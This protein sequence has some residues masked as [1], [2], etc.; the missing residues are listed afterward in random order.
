MKQP[1]ADRLASL[2][3]EQRALLEFRLQKKAAQSS[4]PSIPIRERRDHLPLSVDQER[5]WFVHQLDPASAAYNIYTAVRFKGKLQLEALTRSLNEIV[6]RHEIMRTCF[7]APDGQPEQLI[8]PSLTAAI[9]LVDLRSIPPEFR[10]REA[11]RLAASNVQRPFDLAHLP[12]F[13]TV[14]LQVQDEEFICPTVFHHIITDWVSFYAFDRELASL[15]GAFREGQPS[16]LEPLSI[17]YADFAAWQRDWLTHKVLDDQVEYWRRRLQ[18]APPL[19]ELPYDRPRP[20]V[21][22]ASGF[23]QPLALSPGDTEFIRE[24]GRRYQLT[25]FI[26]LLALFKILLFRLTRQ[27]HVVVGSPIANRNRPEL[28]K[29]LGFFIN[30]LVFCTETGGDPLFT[31][32]LLRVK[33]T[34]LGAYANQDVPFAK[35]VEEVRPDRDLSRT[36]LTQ[37]VFLFLN[38]EQ[39]GEIRLSGLRILPYMIDSESSKFDMTFS[40]WESESGYSG[41][42]EYN[43][44]LFD[45]TTI[46]RMG[47]QFRTLVTSLA[48]N[49]GQRLS[50]IPILHDAARQQQ[51]LEWNDSAMECEEDSI[52][53]R[54]QK[55][56]RLRPGSTAVTDDR[57]T[58]TFGQLNAFANRLARRLTQLGVGPESRVGVLLPRSVGMVVAWLAVL[59]AGGAYLPLADD[60]PRARWE[61]MLEDA[62]ARVLISDPLLAAGYAGVT[63]WIDAPEISGLCDKNLDVVIEP[64]SLAYLIFTSGSTGRPKGVA[65]E[66]RSLS[67]LISWH[68]RAHQVKPGDRA[69]QVAN[70]GFDAAGWEIW[71]YLGAG[72]SVAILSGE[73]RLSPQSIIQYLDDAQVTHCF[74]PTP[75]AEAVLEEDWRPRSL[76]VLLT[77]GD[78]LSRSP[79][80]LAGKLWNHYGPTESTVAATAGLVEKGGDLP[81]IGRPIANT[82][83][84]ILDSS[85]NPVAVGTVGEL[86]LGGRGLARGYIGRAAETA[87]KFVPDQFSR[88]PGQRLYRTG[89]LVRWGR[90]GR[91]HFVGR[92]DEQVKLR[93]YR[94][95]LGE[96]EAQLTALPGVRAAAAV[97]NG[98]GA[99]QRIC[100]YV[101]GD[102]L[103]PEGIRS[104]LRERLPEYMEPSSI[105]LLD[106]LPVTANGKIDRAGLARRE[107][108]PRIAVGSTAPRNQAEETL[109]AIWRETLGL[110]QVGVFDNFFALGGDSILSMRVVA[111]ARA[112]GLLLTPRQIFEQQTIAGLAAVAGSSPELAADR[113]LVTGPAALAPIQRWFLE[114]DPIDAHHFNQALMLKMELRPSPAVLRCVIAGIEAHH[115]ALRSRFSRTEAGWNV[116]I[117]GP[118]EPP[119]IWVNLR[120][121]APSFRNVMIEASAA[122]LQRGLNLGS[123]PLFRVAFF[124]C[125]DPLA[126]RLLVIAHHL[127]V[128]G[129][130]WRILLEDLETALLQASCGA[131]I[132]LPAKTASYRL[133]ADQMP[134]QSARASGVARPDN[135]VASCAAVEISLDAAKTG[136]LLEQAGPAFRTQI[137]DLLLTA[138]SDALAECGTPNGAVDF[139][140]HGRD[141]ASNDLDLSRTVGWFTVI[142]TLQPASNNSGPL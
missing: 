53:D 11:A 115:D 10:E 129:V 113:G 38:P 37:V 92:A 76:C 102:N 17:Q 47:E 27:A 105:C 16:P 15:Y 12:L 126:S 60:T 14:L 88:T 134:P 26:A 141:L 43:P 119:L 18:G 130:S 121:A 41:W 24:I 71:P 82:C 69:T 52:V 142:R 48:E 3:P 6:H 9:P 108:I 73:Q 39:Q 111:R 120:D 138:C 34:A 23:R 84:Y 117:A 59:K 67:N 135:T 109:A 97:V 83:A 29:L 94:I 51:L 13:R 65:I 118:G 123:G 49:P 35:V 68:E 114:Q 112:A 103:E 86:Y 2:S 133:A 25:P 31:E 110:P 50:A 140:G 19:I 85:G 22:T 28:E 40:L 54:V 101:S 98:N 56:T 132:C 80:H 62:G 8:A 70:A 5:L 4:E 99:R 104:R 128:D 90:N 72:A 137:Q 44:D 87:E 107:D 75:L 77:G 74:L 95:E 61:G 125:A 46:L 93:G 32:F 78:R 64:Q 116:K 81:D 55:Q 42:I 91:L 89:D 58:L 96:I 36:P 79:G 124:D 136:V 139:E 1:L 45:R 131:P 33:K 63:L 106:E 30:H 122:A 66:H 57:E 20:P 21:Q 7:L 100:A 127:V